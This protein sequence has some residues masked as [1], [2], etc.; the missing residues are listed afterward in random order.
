MGYVLYKAVLIALGV[1]MWRK[2]AEP[3]NRVSETASFGVT[4]LGRESQ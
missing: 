3:R 1:S 2:S 4:T